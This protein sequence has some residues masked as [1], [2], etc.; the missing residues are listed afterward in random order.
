MSHRWESLSLVLMQFLLMFFYLN[1]GH[2]WSLGRTLDMPGV[3]KLFHWI[4]QE[5]LDFVT[6]NKYIFKTSECFCH[7]VLLCFPARP[8]RLPVWFW[9]FPSDSTSIPTEA[10]KRQ[11]YLEW[12]EYFMAVA[13]LSAQRSKDPSSQVSSGFHHLPPETLS[14][15]LYTH[16]ALPL[17]SSAPFP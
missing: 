12:S 17:Y 6:A 11:D 16:S 10:R 3:Y 7:V 9:V 8:V 13:F 1:T 2:Y 5:L 15:T 4:S 14:L